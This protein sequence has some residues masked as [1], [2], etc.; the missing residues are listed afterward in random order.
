MAQGP[1]KNK[2]GKG[3]KDP[4]LFFTSIEADSYFTSLIF[5]TTAMISAGCLS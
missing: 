1:E 3:P 2:K 5:F 4:C